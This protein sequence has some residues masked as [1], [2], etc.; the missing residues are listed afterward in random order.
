MLKASFL[1]A[2]SA[3]TCFLTGLC[4]WAATFSLW[5]PQGTFQ[6]CSVQHCWLT[7]FWVFS[8]LLTSLLRREWNKNNLHLNGKLHLTPW[9]AG[10]GWTFLGF[11]TSWHL[12]LG[13]PNPDK[14]MPKLLGGEW[15]SVTIQAVTMFLV[16]GDLKRFV[17]DL[18][19][20]QQICKVIAKAQRFRILPSDIYDE[21][22]L[23]MYFV[24]FFLR[25]E[26]GWIGEKKILF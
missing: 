15:T 4:G 2:T 25:R 26:R 18:A 24:V 22:I 21:N 16:H 6:L 14:E 20:V 5:H 7:S 12:G 13:A 8:I 19:L 9:Q 1:W 23:D 17:F 10:C 11:V 3:C